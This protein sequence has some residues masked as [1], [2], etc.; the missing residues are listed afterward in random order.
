MTPEQYEDLITTKTLVQDMHHSLFGNGQPGV[1][2]D[3]QV[4]I[5]GLE[6]T[7]SRSEGVLWA[8]SGIVSAIGITDIVKFFKAI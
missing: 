6:K 8:L 5:E 2:K 4:K 1:I 3:L 7:K